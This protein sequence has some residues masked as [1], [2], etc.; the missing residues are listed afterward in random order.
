MT[1]PNNRLFWSFL[2][3]SWASPSFLPTRLIPRL[4]ASPTAL[5]R[6]MGVLFIKAQEEVGQRLYQFCLSGSTIASQ[7]NAVLF[8]NAL[9]FSDPNFALN[10]SI[11]I[12][13]GVEEWYKKAPQTTKL[14]NPQKEKKKNHKTQKPRKLFVTIKLSIQLENLFIKKVSLEQF[15]PRAEISHAAMSWFW[16]TLQW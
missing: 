14:K 5:R 9:T 11:L 10:C 1:S 15:P 13:A 12:S 16:C 6:G 8:W 7:V 3:L 2:K 4:T